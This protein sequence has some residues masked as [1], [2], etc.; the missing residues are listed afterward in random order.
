MDRLI[1]EQAVIDCF[2]KSQPYIAT[3]LHEFEKELFELPS[4]N[5]QEPKTDVLNKIRAEIKEKIEQEEFARSVFRH[6]EKDA[7][8]AEQCMGSI[9][10]YNNAIKLIDKYRNEVS[11]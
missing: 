8:K 1:S 7:V 9:M 3:R 10:S 5:P 6:E 2:K 11:E 4:V